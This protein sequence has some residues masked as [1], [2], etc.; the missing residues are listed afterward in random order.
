[1][2]RDWN[3]KKQQQQQKYIFI[4]IHDRPCHFVNFLSR[5]F[6]NSFDRFSAGSLDWN[7]III[8][9]CGAQ[10]FHRFTGEKNKIEASPSSVLFWKKKPG[11]LFYH[12]RCC[13]FIGRLFTIRMYIETVCS[14]PAYIIDDVYTPKKERS[15]HVWWDKK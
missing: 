13:I 5:F 4:S 12:S 15:V 7:E 11:C 10:H 8:R 2:F 1:M 9:T 6:L 3:R 14:H